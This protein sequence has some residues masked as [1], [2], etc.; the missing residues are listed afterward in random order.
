M[1]VHIRGALK[2]TRRTIST[3]ALALFLVLASV[4]LQARDTQKTPAKPLAAPTKSDPAQAT[5]QPAPASEITIAVNP[6]TDG[7]KSVTGTYI[8]IDSTITV[9][10][11]TVESVAGSA[12][13]ARVIQV[14]SAVTVD[15]DHVS[16][17]ATF[18]QAL[19][20]GD[21]ICAHAY[22][23]GGEPASGTAERELRDDGAL[24]NVMSSGYDWGRAK[25]YFTLGS[26]F[27]RS[28][29]AFGSPNVFVAANI[30]YNWL[31][32]NKSPKQPSMPVGELNNP[33]FARARLVATGILPA[34][35]SGKTETAVQ[36]KQELHDD[37]KPK[38]IWLLNTWL[39]ARL[40]QIPTSNG[41]PTIQQFQG[42]SLEGGLYMPLILP[43]TQWTFNGE[44][45]AL[46]IAPLAKAGFDTP[47]SNAAGSSTTTG[48]ATNTMTAVQNDLK[49]YYG[50]GFRLGHYKMPVDP[51]SEAP[52]LLSFLDITGGK[53]QE[54]RGTNNN[55][56]ARL[57]ING[58]MKVPGTQFFVGAE[59]NAGQGPK[60]IRFTFGTTV[61][62]GKLLG[63][64]IP[65]TP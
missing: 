46:F 21:S 57:D 38:F 42:G 22:G 53:W 14:A 35:D 45:N 15:K 36:L 7:D 51:T 48:S 44:D 39:E 28:N 25:V 62:V 17:T 11:I 55:A 13:S 33:V 16:F 3:A 58:R 4:S 60:D 12:T 5:S 24:V 31:S 64:L 63:K 2:L 34:P 29:G 49:H 61:D 8:L 54:Y 10:R 23:T 26:L 1:N 41:T 37:T 6:P 20:E 27:A 50:F 47:E 52:E 9:T 32:N 30:D 43:Q 56:S 59:V 18:G 40:T 65:T 19:N